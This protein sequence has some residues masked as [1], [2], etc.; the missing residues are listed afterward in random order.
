MRLEWIE[1]IT[2]LP[3]EGFGRYTQTEWQDW[4]ELED[5]ARREAR[6]EDRM[7]GA[8]NFQKLK[9][10]SPRRC[11]P[12]YASDHGG[13]PDHESSAPDLVP[14]IISCAGCDDPDMIAVCPMCDLPRCRLCEDAG[15]C[16]TSPQAE[17]GRLRLA[18]RR[19]RLPADRAG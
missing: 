4:F 12:G 11:M 13:D 8:N 18:A 15:R 2:G 9:E 17:G 1:W 19:Q 10:G 7:R 3:A 5:A 16:C 14:W 6:E